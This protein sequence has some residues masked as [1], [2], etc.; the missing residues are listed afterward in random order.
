MR[1]AIGFPTI[2]LRPTTTHSAPRVSKA[3][4]RVLWIALISAAGLAI[5]AAQMLPALDHVHDSARSRPFDFDLVSAWS[6]PWAKFG[7]IVFPNILGRRWYSA[8][9][10]RPHN[11]A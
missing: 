3:I 9:V 11:A 10:A 2:L 6:M 4:T 1:A 8:P 7:E 5:G